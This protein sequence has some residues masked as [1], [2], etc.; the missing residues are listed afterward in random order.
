[1]G[2]SSVRS[3][4]R[5][6][7]VDD[8]ETLRD[9]YAALLQDEGY[10]VETA[11]AGNEAYEKMSLGGYDLVL[12]DLMIPELSGTEI[13]EK[14]HL[15]KPQKPNKAVVALT[16]LADEKVAAHLAELGVKGYLVKSNYTP[17]VLLAE[18]KKFL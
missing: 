8:E 5:V 16:N 12:L 4:T 14:L 2:S 1:M 15:T 18:V 10:T 11:T 3:S 9:F 7:V 6:L 13:V 17:D